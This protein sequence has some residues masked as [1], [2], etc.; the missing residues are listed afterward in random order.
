ML[1][2][3]AQVVYNTCTKKIKNKEKPEN[4]KNGRAKS[5]SP[6]DLLESP[7]LT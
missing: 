3:N 7:T 6:I 1:Y 5:G 4:K 2:I